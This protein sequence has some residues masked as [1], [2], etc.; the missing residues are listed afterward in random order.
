MTVKDDIDRHRLRRLGAAGPARDQRVHGVHDRLHVVRRESGARAR[1][2][3]TTKACC[4]RSRSRRR[5]GSILNSTPPAAGGARALIGHFFP[6]MVIR[7]WR[8]RCRS[9]WWRPSARRCGASTCPACSARD[10]KQRSPTC[11]SST[12]ATAPRTTATARNVLSWPSNISSTPVEMIE[13]LV[14]AQ[15]AATGACARAPAATASYRGGNGQ[16]ILFE[17]R[18]PTPITVAFLA[19]RTRAEAAPCGHR[20]RRARARRASVLIDGKRVDPKAQHVVDA[21]AAPC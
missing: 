6:M 5:E 20:G 10:G 1:A 3:R 15:G 18:A 17:S 16:E 4:G 9:A 14:A 7:R 8:R 13:Q 12:A 2:F 19:E 21:R 11:S